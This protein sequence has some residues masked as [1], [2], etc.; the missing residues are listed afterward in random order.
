MTKGVKRRLGPAK[1]R[2]L[3][4]MIGVSVL[5]A[6][7]TGCIQFAFDDTGSEFLFSWIFCIVLSHWVLIDEVQKIETREKPRTKWVALIFFFIFVIVVISI[8]AK[9]FADIGL[10]DGSASDIHDY[11]TALYFSVITW[12]TV[13]YGDVLATSPS[14]RFFAALEALDGYVV[15]ALLIATLVPVFQELI[16]P[17]RNPSDD[18]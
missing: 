7:L 14:A 12:M 15:L 10:K 13:G 3:R 8:Y 5:S 11:G 18:R 17:P 16:R 2:W 4:L 9:I 1:M 6:I